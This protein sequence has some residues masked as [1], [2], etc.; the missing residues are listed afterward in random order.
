MRDG[1][2]AG[3]LPYAAA[4]RV[5]DR[6]LDAEFGG[7]AERL[8][9]GALAAAYP[10][11]RF[12]AGWRL[13]VACPDGEDRRVDL[14]ISP[15]FPAG[16]PRTALVDRPPYL[17][18][19][20]IERDGV[21]CLLPV[22]AEVDPDDP[23]EVA[24]N[25]L[26]KSARLVAELLEGG[27]V[28]RDFREEFLTYWFYASDPDAPRVRSLVRPG[29]PSRPLT[30]W[31]DRDGAMTVAEE[32]E[33]LDRWVNNLS[34]LEPG[35]KAHRHEPAALVWLP[36][37]MLPSGYPL[38]G[39]DLL[40]LAA[41]AGD[42]AARVL[43]QLAA[44][45]VADA[46]VLIGAQGRDGPGLVAVS[47]TVADRRPTARS[48]PDH[49]LTKGFRHR[50]LP[51]D[52]AAMRMFSS[53]PLRRSVVERADAAPTRGPIG[54]WAARSFCSAAGR[55]GPASPPGWRAS[56]SAG[57]IWSIPSG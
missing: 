40:P 45:T 48:G 14:L 18:W 9:S 22:G 30:V 24:V 51:S 2:V 17:E 52:V 5:L 16:Y 50:P 37:P 12:S 29:G 25:L 39:A 15:A 6:R 47:T 54:C 55:S 46:L 32:G 10:T 28:D 43:E 57:C 33:T 34:G 49:P 26:A 7:A 20:H 19:P 42:G 36:E 53:A 38:T 41:K 13:S 27:I 31:R 35:R 21:L 1:M 3:R 4:L 56:V 8:S 11:R 23:S 44:G